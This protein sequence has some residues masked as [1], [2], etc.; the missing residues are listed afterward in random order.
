MHQIVIVDDSTTT[1]SILRSLSSKLDGV[2]SVAFTDAVEALDYLREN[3]ANLVIVDYSMPS[4]TGIEIAKRL[5]RSMRHLDT[6]IIMLTASKEPTV[7]TR[8]LEVGVTAFLNK[9][10]RPQ[11]FKSCVLKHMPVSESAA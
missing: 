8:A 7:R 1:A 9:P 6:P 5:R 10:V 11:E 4:I 2:N 3:S